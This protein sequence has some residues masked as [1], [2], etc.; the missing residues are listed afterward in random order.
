MIRRGTCWHPDAEERDKGVEPA[1]LAV[2]TELARGL[3][4]QRGEVYVCETGAFPGTVTLALERARPYAGSLR[5][6]VGDRYFFDSFE[7]EPEF[8][9]AHGSY[10]GSPE[11]YA[12]YDLTVLDS[13]PY[14]LRDEEFCTWH[15]SAPALSVLLVHD[16]LDT[17]WRKPWPALGPPPAAVFG[18]EWGLG[19]WLR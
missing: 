11:S 3:L 15:N 13:S 14:G 10:P 7:S 5:A 16:V 19:L 9:V 12:D 8:A 17:R 1:L 2:I 18:M 6:G 4:R